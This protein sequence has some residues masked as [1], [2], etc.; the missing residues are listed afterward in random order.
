MRGEVGG[1]WDD[2]FIVIVFNA[3]ALATGHGPLDQFLMNDLDGYSSDPFVETVALTFDSIVSDWPAHHDR[4]SSTMAIW[5]D[6]GHLSGPANIIFE[7]PDY[8]KPYYP[9]TPRII[10]FGHT[11]QAEFSIMP[12]PWTPS[13]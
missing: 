7:M 6:L 1:I 9:F 11:H 4:V 13:T 3:I 10:L 12:G 5:D 2:A 8:L